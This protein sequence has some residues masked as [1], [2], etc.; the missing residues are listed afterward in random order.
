MFGR[1]IYR[2]LEY[3]GVIHRYDKLKAK[4]VQSTYDTI[5]AVFKVGIAVLFCLVLVWVSVLFYVLFY[6]TYV[7]AIEHIK[8]VHLQFSSCDE[9]KLQNG[10]K[11]MCG[12]PEAHVQLTRYHS[13]LMIGQPYKITVIM[14]L[15]ES[16]AN[17]QLGMFM[18]CGRLTGKGGTT[19]ANSCRSSMLR[20][21]S[22][23]LQVLRLFALGPLFVFDFMEE[24]QTLSIELFPSFEED[25]NFPVTDIFLELKSNQIEV[26]S[27]KV[28]ID[29]HL[30]GLRY[31]MFHW[32]FFSAVLGSVFNLGV[33]IFVMLL[34]WYKLYGPANITGNFN[35]G[36][37]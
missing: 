7:P 32:P 4:T 24:K 26:Y 21:R 23:L 15:P 20:Y 31:L 9:G 16:E 11:A 33:I 25:Q 36:D 18:V 27:S 30:S 28:Q 6:Y 13:L 17:K 29:A 14:E 19:V 5:D 37:D 34:S 35:F 8:P 1:L 12:F 3:L 10:N 2:I 22:P